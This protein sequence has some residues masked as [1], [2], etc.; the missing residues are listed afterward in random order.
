[1]L[2]L[3]QKA[4]AAKAAVSL[5]TTEQKNAALE[6]MAQALLDREDAIL[7][8]KSSFSPVTSQNATTTDWAQL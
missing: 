6:A 2:E 4:K 7:A 1:M 5:L 8:A 3:L